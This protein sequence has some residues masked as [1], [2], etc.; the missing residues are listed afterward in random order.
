MKDTSV[1]ILL[2]EY[3]R[4]KSLEQFW[5]ENYE[6]TLQIYL[7][8]ITVATGGLIFLLG[9][10]STPSALR[11]NVVLLLSTVL[12][13]G[14]ISYLRLMGMEIILAEKAKALQLIRGKFMQ[15]DTE[16]EMA[17]PKG[18]L[19][20]TKR[21]R[22]WSSVRGIATRA[23]IVSG[24]KTIVV[25]LNSLVSTVITVVIVWPQTLWLGIVVGLGAALLTAIL[26]SIH[27]AWMYRITSKNMFMGNVGNWI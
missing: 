19:H 4:L 10:P 18:L 11:M 25:L 16:L 21:Y 23:L 17:F 24:A 1:Q 20:D 9:S 14:E 26:H 13:V 6:R 15:Q 3:D 27:A 8:V 12:L 2:S 7:T 22:S 5:L